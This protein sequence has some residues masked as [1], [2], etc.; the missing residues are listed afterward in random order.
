MSKVSVLREGVLHFIE[1]HTFPLLS[2]RSMANASENGNDDADENTEFD[3]VTHLRHLKNLFQ[4]YS[5][6]VY[7]WVRCSIADNCGVNNHM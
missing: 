2:V 6:D 1:E 4:N 3:A 7:D 5:I